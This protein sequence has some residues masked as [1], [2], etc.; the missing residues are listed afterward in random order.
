MELQPARLSSD[1]AVPGYCANKERNAGHEFVGE[2]L[3]CLL[4]S[5]LH[6]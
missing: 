1:C 3:F 6:S 2:L 5:I 4:W